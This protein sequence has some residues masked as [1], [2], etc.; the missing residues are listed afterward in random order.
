MQLTGLDVAAFTRDYWQ[1]Q[2]LLL[3]GAWDEWVDPLDADELAGL[4]CEEH[5]EARL[6]MRALDGFAVEQGP[7]PE[8][9]FATLGPEPWTLLVNAV[10]HHV[11]EVAALLEPFRFIPDWRVDDVMV[12]YATNGG[13]VGPH[14]D[15]YDVFLIQGTGSRRWQIGRVCDAAAMLVPHDELRLLADFEPEEE[16]ILEPGDILYLPPGVAHNGTAIGD[17]CM[18]YSV[19]FRA[20]ARAELIAHWCDHVLAEIQEDDRYGDPSLISQDNPGEIAPEAISKLHAMALEKLQDRA[21]FGRWFGEYNSVPKYPD[22]DWSP[23]APLD[24]S[25]V[26]TA[27][28]AGT[29]LCRNPASR[30]SF[31]RGEGGAVLLF[32]DGTSFPCAGA[33]AELAE[34][35]CRTNRGSLDAGP[36]AT[37]A[38]TALIVALCN[39][40]SLAFAPWY[41]TSI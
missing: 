39:Q 5:V 10:D 33:A 25:D 31:I 17:G 35:I 20:P 11:P 15:Q 6:V 21:E 13:G 18:T 24:Q 37:A 12:S 30:F 7:F 38:E 2:P 27:L 36:A 9:R 41:Q 32:V 14:F 26:A 16:W 34:R 8:D 22:V 3:R 19:G 23:S 40:G 1:K 29:A 4:A 28:A